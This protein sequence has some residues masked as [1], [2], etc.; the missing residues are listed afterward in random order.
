MP[1]MRGEGGIT[2][3]KDGRLTVRITMPSGRRL[4]R[5]IGAMKDGRA[6]RRL[7]ERALR[8]LRDARAADLEPSSQTLA[9]YLRS[10]L[11]GLRDARHA[12]VRPRTIEFYEA[13]CEGHIIPTLGGYRL[14]RLS[15]VHVEGWLDHE[16][17]S[18]RSLHH[19]RS[20]L[21]RALNVALRRRIVARNVAAAVDLPDV[22]NFEGNPLT[23]DEARRLLEATQG[24]RLGALWRLAIVTGLRQGELLGM[25]WDDI[26]L[27]AGTV[28]VTAQ[29]QR[30]GGSWVRVEPKADRA[31]ER[32]AIDRATVDLLRAHKLRQAAERQPGWRYW[33][34]AFVSVHGNPI[35]RTEALRAFHAACD[36][37][38]IARRRM[39]DLRGTSA[40]ILK[41]LD[42]PEDVRM[43]RLGHATTKV[44]R[45][46]A[47]AS[48]ALD[49]A[50]VERLAE[51]I[52]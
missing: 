17:G 47:K 8:E 2:R 29:L 35:H 45:H 13:V 34:L 40:T 9:A 1:E 11:A 3:R 28:T 16:A 43:A 33:G 37:A 25:G 31:I 7:A 49:R 24:D 21:R 38:G 27:D 39:H 36:A 10:W 23:A 41:D 52:A 32:I 20:V 12:K 46:Y 5:T 50:A 26:D 6:Q 15:E 42:I 4:T 30:Q 51:A 14:D 44:H 22:P 19:Y 18:L 48:E